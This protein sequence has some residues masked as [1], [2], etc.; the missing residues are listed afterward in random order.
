MVASIVEWLNE[1]DGAALA[2]LTFAYVV[3]SFIL[4]GISL[5]TTKLSRMQL[6]AAERF[7]R[8][9]SRPYVTVHFVE[10]V[11][12]RIELLVENAGPTAA[13]KVQITTN[14]EIKDLYQRK[15]QRQESKRHPFI[16]NGFA[17]LPPKMIARSYIGLTE[18]IKQ[19]YQ[20]SQI[21]GEVKFEDRYG[22]VYAEPVLINPTEM[23]GAA[24]FPEPS[25]A[26]ELAK[27]RELLSKTLGSS[28]EDEEK[29][30]H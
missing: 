8:E 28:S 19:E 7:E 6:E 11:G 27:I 24:Y 10:K 9:R 1:N 17:Y 14:P 29:A 15:C 5:R 23:H 25:T 3:I 16:E 13:Y 26:Q 30:S 4:V 22:T 12:A 20:N 21:E 2:L 18:D